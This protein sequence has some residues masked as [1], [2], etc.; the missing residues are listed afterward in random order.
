MQR[1]I[2]ESHERG[3][4]ET[5]GCYLREESDEEIESE[6]PELSRVSRRPNR[7]A[8]DCVRRSK[9][10]GDKYGDREEKTGRKE[11]RKERTK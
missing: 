2:N 8:E 7:I 11:E 5:G 1:K 9:R 4:K 10:G 6:I 3:R